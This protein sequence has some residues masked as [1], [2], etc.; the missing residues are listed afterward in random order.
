MVEGPTVGEFKSL[1]QTGSYNMRIS[2]KNGRAVNGCCKWFKPKRFKAS[3][4]SIF[5][6]LLLSALR[7][8]NSISLADGLDENQQP[9]HTSEI[10]REPESAASFDKRLPP[11]IPGEQIRDGN[12]SMSVISTAGEVAPYDKSVRAPQ[13]DLPANMGGVGGVIVDQRFGAGF[14]EPRHPRIAD[15]ERRSDL[16]FDQRDINR[17]QHRE[18]ARGGFNNSA[19]KKI[20]SNEDW[21]RAPEE[22][23]ETA[24]PLIMEPNTQP[25]TD[26]DSISGV[27]AILG[28]VAP[29]KSPQ[30]LEGEDPVL[31]E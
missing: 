27:G 9:V 20:E 31:R 7:E 16:E 1:Q 23:R 19:E 8:G 17:G 10:S 18:D 30:T 29:G 6:A 12:R 21:N 11:V 28:D 22:K 5:A 13:P 4:L 14:H 25:N 15:R 2:G 26:P 24:P 3:M